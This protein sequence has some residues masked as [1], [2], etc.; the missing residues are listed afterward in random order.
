MG[1]YKLWREKI[2]G[3]VFDSSYE[4]GEPAESKAKQFII[5]LAEALT[6]MQEGFVWKIYIPENLGYGKWKI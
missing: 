4:R 5:G 1:Y 6:K 3:N 2:D